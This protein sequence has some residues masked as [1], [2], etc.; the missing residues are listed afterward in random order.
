MKIDIGTIGNL[1]IQLFGR[2]DSIVLQVNAW[3]TA[4]GKPTYS[5]APSSY[6]FRQPGTVGFP[7]R[8]AFTVFYVPE[9]LSLGRIVAQ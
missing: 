4:H 8:I 9:N 6:S 5:E 7:P 2:W 1:L 3:A